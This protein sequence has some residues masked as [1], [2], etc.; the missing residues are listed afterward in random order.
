[1]K[2]A[3][4]NYIQSER[5]DNLYTPEYAILPLIKYLPK[6]KNIT[7]WECC[8]YGD[9]KITK[10]LKENGYNVVSTDIVSGFN[11]LTDEPDF[12]FDMIITNPPYSIKNEWLQKCYEYNKPFALLLPVT[13]LE[14]EFRGSLYDKY[15]IST[16]ILNKRVNFTDKNN[17]WFNT[18]W[19]VW[20]LEGLPNN[21]LYFEKIIK[22]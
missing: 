18:S 22:E 6:N 19:F 16:I 8:D 12:E 20:N 5:N 1:M 7:I 17:V 11:F 14:G 21:K 2:K 13:A 10:L 4:I 9:S 15:G 3:M